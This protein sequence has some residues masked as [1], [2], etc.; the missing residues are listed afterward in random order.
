[1][2]LHPNPNPSPSPNPNPNPRPQPQPLH[3]DQVSKLSRVLA[4]LEGGDNGVDMVA[5]R[6]S[7]EGMALWPH[8]SFALTTCGACTRASA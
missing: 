3:P 5:V 2:G 1:M 7:I 6:R 8:P 4:L